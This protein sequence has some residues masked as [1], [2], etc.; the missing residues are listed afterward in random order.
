MFPNKKEMRF[1][2]LKDENIII[3]FSFKQENLGF[4]HLCNPQLPNFFIQGANFVT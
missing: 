1:L 2:I 4:S 3:Y